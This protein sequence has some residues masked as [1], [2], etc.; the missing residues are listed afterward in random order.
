LEFVHFAPNYKFICIGSHDIIFQPTIAFSQLLV[1]ISNPDAIFSSYRAV[2][3]PL[4]N[5]SN[6]VY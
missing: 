1:L 4:S 5:V 3:Q 6:I 2:N